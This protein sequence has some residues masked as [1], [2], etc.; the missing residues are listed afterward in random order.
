MF[1]DKLPS[2]RNIGMTTVIVSTTSMPTSHIKWI[3]HLEGK[4]IDINVN[5]LSMV[6]RA[7]PSKSSRTKWSSIGESR[8]IKN[9]ITYSGQWYD[10][11]RNE[12][13]QID[14]ETAFKQQIL[15]GLPF[16][17]FEYKASYLISLKEDIQIPH[18][19][20]EWGPLKSNKG[21]LYVFFFPLT[22][23]GM[24]LQVWDYGT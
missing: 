7:A 6:A 3:N 9:F 10:Y 17:G 11:C 5:F 22:Y 12:G 20:Y 8:H 4:I 15:E 23:E 1:L 18:I 16:Q 14:Y 19:D 13:Y 21:K 2:P 24:Q